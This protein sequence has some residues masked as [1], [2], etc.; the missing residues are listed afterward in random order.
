[1][2]KVY[3]LLGSNLNNPKENLLTAQ[4]FIS[5][6]LGSIMRLSSLYQTGAW[7]NTQQPD[8]INQVIVVDTEHTA[9]QCIDIILTIEQAMGRVRTTKNAPR[10]IDIDILYFNKEII[11]LPHLIV[12]H[13]AIQLRK[14]VLIPL[15][16]ISPHF[17]HPVFNQNNH[18]LLEKCEDQLNVKK[19]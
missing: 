15:N 10:L 19:I 4:A 11:N 8:F 6:K 3:L 14:F 17:V 2:N 9:L 5:E 1:M 16:E 13:P 12:P 18:Q 7:G